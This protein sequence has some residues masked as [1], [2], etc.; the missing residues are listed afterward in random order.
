MAISLTVNVSLG[1]KRPSPFFPPQTRSGRTKADATTFTDVTGLN[2]VT[3]F[4]DFNKVIT[5]N[6]LLTDVTEFEVVDGDS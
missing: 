4:T 6:H 2:D 3:D 1:R 5:L